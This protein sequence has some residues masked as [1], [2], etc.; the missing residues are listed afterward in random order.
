MNVKR[1]TDEWERASA[2]DKNMSLDCQAAGDDLVMA[3]LNLEEERD[4]AVRDK[5]KYIAEVRRL[6]AALKEGEDE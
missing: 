1:L 5:A 6:R 3:V 4:A 2:S